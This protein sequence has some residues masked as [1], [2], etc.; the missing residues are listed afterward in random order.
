MTQR[1]C[2]DHFDRTGAVL[3]LTKNGV[4][5]RKSCTRQTL[6]DAWA[7][8]WEGLNGTPWQMVAPELKLT[9][10]VTADKGVGQ[11]SPRNVVEHQKLNPEVFTSCLRTLKHMDLRA[12]MCRACIA[13][14]SDPLRLA[15]FEEERRGSK[16][17]V[18]TANNGSHRSIV[19]SSFVFR[20]GL[21]W[22][23]CQDW[24]QTTGLSPF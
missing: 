3:G 12:R 10:K 19:V 9:K 18:I 5:R 14:K 22:H 16:H 24:Q 23:Q 8:N 2:I 21:V 20:F 7:T 1:I 4:V 15:F 17:K 11:T 6:S 13:W